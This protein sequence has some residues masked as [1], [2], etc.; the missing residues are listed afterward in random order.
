MNAD[1]SRDT[2][3]LWILELVVGVVVCAMAVLAVGLVA[4]TVLGSASVPGLNAEVCATAS[5]DQLGIRQDAVGGAGDRTRPAALETGIEWRASEVQV[6]D[7][8][9]GV[10]T[11]ALG[12]AGLVVWFGG[13]AVFFVL[14]W[15]FLRRARREGVFADR[16]PGQLRTLGRVLLMWAALDLVLSGWIEAALV[17]RMTDSPF[18]V[19]ATIPWVP[20]LLG[21]ALL[22]LAKVMEQAVEMRHD[23]EATI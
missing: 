15:R 7:P 4:G 18:A 5:G 9:P 6:C 14:L 23:V 19:S 17:Q 13:P 22:G 12:G 10:A 3:P 2:D 21:V 20:L 11:R 1:Q 16:V 8:E